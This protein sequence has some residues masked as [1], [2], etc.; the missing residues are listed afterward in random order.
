MNRIKWFGKLVRFRE[1]I[2]F[3]LEDFK[4]DANNNGA[5]EQNQT[6]TSLTVKLL[7]PILSCFT[8]F[9]LNSMIIVTFSVFVKLYSRT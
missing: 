6:K 1:Y 9:P 5:V 8:S 7:V 3:E 2:V 4:K